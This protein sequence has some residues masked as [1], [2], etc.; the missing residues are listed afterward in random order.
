MLKDFSSRLAVIGKCWLMSSLSLL[1]SLAEN[2]KKGSCQIFRD[3]M[4]KTDSRHMPH[5]DRT[6]WCESTC[7]YWLKSVEDDSGES[8]IENGVHSMKIL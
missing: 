8:M 2:T 1:S 6:S 4:Q 7:I 5:F 3:F